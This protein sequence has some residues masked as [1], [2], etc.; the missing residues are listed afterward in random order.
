M[1]W[2]VCLPHISVYYQLLPNW[3]S[4]LVILA[5]LQLICCSMKDCC[6]WCKMKCINTLTGPLQPCHEV[7]TVLC[8]LGQYLKHDDTMCSLSQLLLNLLTSGK[9]GKQF[10]SSSWTAC[11][12][13]FSVGRSH[14]SIDWQLCINTSKYEFGNLYAVVEL[15]IQVRIQLGF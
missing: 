2:C 7:P 15:V 4:Q 1:H 14:V 12:G 6:R 11:F 3:F 10:Y 8:N 13:T 5:K 9:S